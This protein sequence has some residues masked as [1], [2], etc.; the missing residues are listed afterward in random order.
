MKKVLFFKDLALGSLGMAAKRMVRG[1]RLPSWSWKTEW[2]VMAAGK[3]LER[4][5]EFGFPWFERVLDKSFTPPNLKV[6]LKEVDED[7]L[8]GTWIIPAGIKIG[9]G[10]LLYF[11]GGGYAVKGRRPYMNYLARLA[12]DS[13]VRI[14]ALDY[15]LSREAVYPAAQNDCLDAWFWLLKQGVD[16]S[17][18]ILGGDASGASLCMAVLLALRDA[19]EALPRAAILTSPWVDPVLGKYERSENET[20]S[21]AWI[22]RCM[23]DYLADAPGDLPEVAPLYADLQGLPPLLVQVGTAE[24]I[25]EQVLAFAEKACAEKVM[26]CLKTYREMFHGFQLYHHLPGSSACISDVATFLEE[27]FSSYHQDVV[28]YQTLPN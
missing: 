1:A 15:R 13:G 11:H 5:L 2:D 24:I 20:L 23:K 25:L 4:S 26:V 21:E 10:V 22:S 27:I 19:R 9:K 3:V 16:P 14:F 7:G 18:I 28:F 8:S 6:E 12:V 17:S